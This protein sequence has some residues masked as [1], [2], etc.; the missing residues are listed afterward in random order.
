MAE[1]NPIRYIGDVWIDDP[2]EVERINKLEREADR[3]VARRRRKQRTAT[4]GQV[5]H[6]WVN[7]QEQ[8][9]LARRAEREHV[10]LGIAAKRALREAL[11]LADKGSGQANKMV[12]ASRKVRDESRLVNA[13]FS[14]I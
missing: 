11:G 4:G 8:A 2:V 9:E 12:Q 13:E 7:S 14:A 10:S 5:V 3:D 1:H 6:L